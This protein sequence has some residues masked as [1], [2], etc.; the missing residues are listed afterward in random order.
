[1]A[2]IKKRAMTD[3]VGL[4]AVDRTAQWN[5]TLADWFFEYHN[6]YTHKPV[7]NKYN[8]VQY[9]EE[10]YVEECRELVVHEFTMGDVEDPDL[11][12]AEPLYQWQQSEFGQWVMKHAADTPTWHRM[13]DPISYG[14]KY[15][16]T[17]K[18]I[19]ARLTE[20]LLRYPQ[21]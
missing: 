13:A 18:F 12:A 1:M 9:G 8:I 19:G 6:P 16:I 21:K 4:N 17:A 15:K 11:Y 14:Y 7:R 3:R 20:M 2:M 10:Q 5:Q